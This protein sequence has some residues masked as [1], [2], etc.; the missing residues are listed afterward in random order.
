MSNFHP[1]TATFRNRL[2][3]YHAGFWD[4]DV[5]DVNRVLELY[6]SKTRRRWRNAVRTCERRSDKIR[7]S[8]SLELTEWSDSGSKV[9]SKIQLTSMLL[10]RLLAG[11]S[12]SN[13]N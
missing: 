7:Y 13:P 3:R 10:G 11:N 8:S 4:G 1:D 12:S 9:A 6:V 2:Q 5:A